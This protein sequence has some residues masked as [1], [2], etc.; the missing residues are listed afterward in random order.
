MK[1]LLWVMPILMFG[2]QQTSFA[3]TTPTPSTTPG[4]TAAVSD[5]FD[6]EHLKGKWSFGMNNLFGIFHLNP[7]LWVENDLALDFY[8]GGYEYDVPGTD[9]NNNP[10]TTA[11]WKIGGGFGL[12]EN[13]THPTEGVYMQLVEWVIF[14]D[15]YLENA[16]YSQDWVQTGQNLIGYVGL[17][18]EAFVPFW[19]NLSIEGNVG[20]QGNLGF[21]QTRTTYSGGAVTTSN[22]SGVSFA[23]SNNNLGLMNIAAHF[24]F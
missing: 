4:V 20:V 19:K 21:Q 17:G 14:Q 8:A 10:I 5:K 7:R 23:T 24:Y 1:R 12:R 16:N 18:F 2:L 13:I 3:D 15:Y 22:F 6:P 11:D 9:L